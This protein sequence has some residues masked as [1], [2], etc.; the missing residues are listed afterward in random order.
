M[1]DISVREYIRWLP[2][3]PSE[4]TSTIV[5][6]T[7]NR[8]FVDLRILKPTAR[9]GDSRT[10]DVNLPPSRLDWAIAGTSS[11]TAIISPQDSENPGQQ[12]LVRHGRW[13]HWIDSRTAKC[14]GVVDE[15]DVF[16]NPPDPGLEVERGRMVNPA[17]GLEADYEEG[18]RSV[19]IE[20]VPSPADAGGGSGGGEEAAVSCLAL[21]MEGAEEGDGPGGT[22]PAGGIKRG[23]LVRLGQYCQA[24]ARD[25]DRITVERLKWD[26]GQKRWVTQ[27]RIGDQ[28]LPTEVATYFAHGTTLGD[29]VKV[30]GG[31]IWK[32]V[33]RW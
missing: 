18:W 25:G 31:A 16:D 26:P 22:G 11:S 6:T 1:G 14:D 10:D 30:S 3:E 33:E 2:G 27:V 23:L 12:K 21:R 8:L 20:G 24:F 7:P 15:G 9:D 4:P 32:V 28:A 17:T 13:A 29:E 5:L 19:P